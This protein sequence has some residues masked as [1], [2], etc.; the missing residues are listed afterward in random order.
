MASVRVSRE[1]GQLLLQAL[2]LRGDSITE[3]VR[4]RGVIGAETL[5]PRSLRLAKRVDVAD[6]FVIEKRGAMCSVVEFKR[7]RLIDGHRHRFRGGV[8]F[9]SDVQRDGF[10]FHWRN[11]GSCRGVTARITSPPEPLLVP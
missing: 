2:V 8:A 3:R 1:P 9:V 5:Q 11:L 4:S 10:W 6:D 7:D